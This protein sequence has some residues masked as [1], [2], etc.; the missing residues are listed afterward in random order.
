MCWSVG[1]TLAQMQTTKIVDRFCVRAAKSVG[2]ATTAVIC[3]QGVLQQHTHTRAH[4]LN[5]H[6]L[7]PRYGKSPAT[8]WTEK[9]GGSC[10]EAGYLLLLVFSWGWHCGRERASTDFTQQACDAVKEGCW[11]GLV[12]LVRLCVVRFETM[13]G[14]GENDAPFLRFS[15]QLSVSV[16]S[17]LLCGND[18]TRYLLCLNR[19]LVIFSPL[20]YFTLLYENYC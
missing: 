6:N 20:L 4:I 14:Q 13:R 16:A 8:K 3:H 10:R 17:C 2:L 9:G 5:C 1:D 15:G 11:T 18:N 19:S 7:H 12:V